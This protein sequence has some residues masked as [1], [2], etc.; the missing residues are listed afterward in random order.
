MPLYEYHCKK[1]G[2]TEEVMKKLDELGDIVECTE[3]E[4]LMTRSVGNRGGFR[5]EGGCWAKDGYS[6][7]LGDAHKF[8]TRNP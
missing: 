2:H 8:S 4:Y 6:T 5:L 7:F 1:C 3:C